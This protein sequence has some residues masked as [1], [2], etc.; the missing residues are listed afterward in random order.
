MRVLITT[1]VPEVLYVIEKFPIYLHQG[2]AEAFEAP[3]AGTEQWCFNSS[4]I[5][6]GEIKTVKIHH[7]V[8][9]LDKIL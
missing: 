7:L 9:G 6:S 3:T 2:T 1:L 8:P 4:I 5:S